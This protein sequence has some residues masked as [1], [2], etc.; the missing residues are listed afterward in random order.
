MHNLKRSIEYARQLCSVFVKPL[1]QQSL[2]GAL[3]NKRLSRFAI[4]PRS[5]AIRSR[6]KQG[7]PLWHREGIIAIA[8]RTRAAVLDG[9]WTD[10][11]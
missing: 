1:A 4:H 8:A 11:P 2:L 5:T 6:I 7:S 10:V 9:V 3:G